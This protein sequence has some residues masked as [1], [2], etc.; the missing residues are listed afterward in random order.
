MLRGGCDENCQRCGPSG[1]DPRG[2]IVDI[3]TAS[4]GSLPDDP[5]A[6]FD[7]WDELRALADRVSSADAP[8]ERHDLL[9]PVPR[10]WQV[11]AIGLNYAAHAAEA[12]LKPPEFPPTFT[13]F[14]TCL[15]GPEATVELPSEFVD[16]EVELVVVIGRRCPRGRCR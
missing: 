3:A 11:F 15:A 13:K 7:H 16:W 2:G 9:A 10:P 6:V 5:Q 8:L 12:G 1:V 14:P 4:R